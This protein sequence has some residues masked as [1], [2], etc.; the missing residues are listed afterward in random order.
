MYILTFNLC[1][2]SIFFGWI[3]EYFLG[4]LTCLY[5][6]QPKVLNLNQYYKVALI[7]AEIAQ[8]FFLRFNPNRLISRTR[9]SIFFNVLW[10]Q[11]RHLRPSF[12]I[13]FS[14]SNKNYDWRVVFNNFTFRTISKKKDFSFI[15]SWS[16]ISTTF[17][18][19]SK[20][21]RKT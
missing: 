12:K 8:F 7:Q 19:S 10:A 21:C 11:T 20:W 3:F 14:Y 15:C 18:S 16:P 1:F 13:K 6:T 4:V 5:P 9:K 17:L 2:W